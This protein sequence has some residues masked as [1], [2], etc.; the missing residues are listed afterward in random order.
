MVKRIA[1]SVLAGAGILFAY[2]I[3]R[4]YNALRII[5]SSCEITKIDLSSSTLGMTLYFDITNPLLLG[6]TLREISGELTATNYGNEPVVIGT[7]YNRYNYYIRGN[8]R[9][10]IRAEVK[11]NTKS[12]VQ[13]LLANIKSG[14]VNNLL[15]NYKGT[16]KFGS[17]TEIPIPINKNM[18]LQE[19][20]K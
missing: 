14:D 2:N 4:G 20:V 17:T 11:I 8:A 12:V 15:I 7:V 5:L 16:L 10:I 6:V 13:Q 1:Y 18:T 3:I 9:H 19:L